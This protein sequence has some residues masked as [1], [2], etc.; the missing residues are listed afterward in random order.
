[1]SW[2]SDSLGEFWKRGDKLLLGLCTLLTLYGIALIYTATRFTGSTRS[3]VVQAAGMVL[4]I[5][6][7]GF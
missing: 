5:F 7:Y 3:A 6:L 2:L 1:M 4:G